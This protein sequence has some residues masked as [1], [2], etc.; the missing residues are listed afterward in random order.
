MPETTMEPGSDRAHVLED[1][2]MVTPHGTRRAVVVRRRSSGA[3]PLDG[4]CGDEERALVDRYQRLVLQHESAEGT[5]RNFIL[6]LE[7]TD[8]RAIVLDGDSLFYFDDQL[9]AP[10]AE[11][12]ARLAEDEGGLED[13]GGLEEEGG[14][15]DEGSLEDEAACS[16]TC[17]EGAPN[18]DTSEDACIAGPPDQDPL[19]FLFDRALDA[20][21]AGDQNLG[22]A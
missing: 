5:P 1:A 19:G 17:P 4:R 15:E 18:E 6:D 20:L 22:H 3:D 21:I 9:K 16:E 11:R 7:G 14:L 8:R 13:D 2:A 12:M 10:D